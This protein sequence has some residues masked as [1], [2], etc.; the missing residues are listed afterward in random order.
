[1]TSRRRIIGASFVLLFTTGL[2]PAVASGRKADATRLTAF[3]DGLQVESRW[4]AGVHVD[5]ETGLPDGKVEHFEGRHTHCSAFVASAAKQLGV[6]ILRPPDHGQALLANA[7][8]EWLRDKGAAS[9]WFAIADGYDAQ[10]AA[11]RGYLVV[12][13]FENPDAQKPG[14]IAIVR[15]SGR[16]R[17]S[18]LTDGPSIVMAGEHNYDSTTVRNG[19][20]NHPGAW[21]DGEIRYWGHDVG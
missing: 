11:N 21:T 16:S 4:P 19:F 2:G 15:P 6:Y 7:Q 10:R 12:A 18:L 17:D 8:F 14:H 3:L 1:M 9:G 13:S 5:W 20:A